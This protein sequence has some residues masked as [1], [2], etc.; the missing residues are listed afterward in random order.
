MTG[1]IKESSKGTIVQNN[2]IRGKGKLP[3][4]NLNMKQFQLNVAI[5]SKKNC[6][7]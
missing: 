1:I 7:S 3:K 5:K 2:L 4:I 6:Q